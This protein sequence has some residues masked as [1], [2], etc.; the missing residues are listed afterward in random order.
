MIGDP[1]LQLMEALFIDY[2]VVFALHNKVSKQDCIE[3]EIHEAGGRAGGSVNYLFAAIVTYQHVC[4][5]PEAL[6]AA[7][8][9]AFGGVGKFVAVVEKD[10]I[11]AEDYL[12]C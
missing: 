4:Y 11:V 1:L 10:D 2:I 12:N 9:G 8:W 3:D 6:V 7:L 5:F